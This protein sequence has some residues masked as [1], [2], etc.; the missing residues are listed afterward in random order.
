MCNRKQCERYLFCIPD[1][2]PGPT[3]YWVLT[4]TGESCNPYLHVAPSTAISALA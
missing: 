2:A 3:V 4:F 1:L